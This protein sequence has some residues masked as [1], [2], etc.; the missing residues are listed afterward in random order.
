MKKRIIALILVVVM[1]VLALVGCGEYKY[2]DANLDKFTSVDT[3][4]F[5][6]A[7]KNLVIE[8]EDEFS[9]DPVKREKELHDIVLR[10]LLN[11][12]NADTEE[13]KEGI[14]DYADA[15]YFCYYAKYID[16][17]GVEHIFNVPKT[18]GKTDYVIL[19][20][21]KVFLQFG[22]NENTENP[23]FAAVE[24]AFAD[25]NIK[26]YI[27]SLDTTNDGTLKV[28]A[29]DKV[30]LT[31]TYTDAEGVQK[32]ISN[33]YVT[34][35]TADPAETETAD[36]NDLKSV[37][38]LK[39]FETF[40]WNLVDK[41]VGKELTGTANKFE[42]TL[43]AAPAEQDGEE[44]SEPAS[45]TYT[46]VTVVG[47]ASGEAV[48]V[49][50]EFPDEDK[51]EL[52]D[53]FGNKVDVKGKEVE[54][55]V[56]PTHIKK[57]DY[58]KIDENST[59]ADYIKNA[60]A[61][62]TVFYGSA[63]VQDLVDENGKT[64][65]EKVGA[66]DIFS[67]EE[68]KIKYTNDEGEEETKTFKEIMEQ[69]AELQETYEE[70]KAT[71]D[72][73]V[74]EYEDA[75]ELLESVQK[76]YD[77]AEAALA[78]ARKTL[79]DYKAA[80]QAV[81]DAVAA[82]DAYKA[83]NPEAGEGDAELE[84]LEAAVAAAKTA[85]EELTDLKAEDYTDAKA[86]EKIKLAEDAVAERNEEFNGDPDDEDDTGIVGE[87]ADAKADLEDACE[88]LYGHVNA[89][90]DLYCDNC[91][92]E[93]Q[94][95][96]GAEGH[97]DSDEDC[98]C[99][100]CGAG[101]NHVDADNNCVCD[102]E[103][104]KAKLT[105]KHIDNSDP[106]D[107]KCDNCNAA[108]EHVDSDDGKCDNCQAEFTASDD[109]SIEAA[110]NDALAE[111]DAYLTEKVL[112]EDYKNEADETK[113]FA[114]TIV[115]EFDENVYDVLENTYFTAINN[116]VMKEAYKVIDKYITV[117]RD[118]LPR[119]AV[120]EIYKKIY[121]G[122]KYDFFMSASYADSTYN[123]YETYEG[124]F[125][126]YLMIKT[127]TDT[128]KAAKAALKEEAKDDVEQIVKIYKAAQILNVV[129]TEEEFE[130]D[131]EK[132]Y[133]ETTALIYE[134]YYGMEYMTE[135][136]LH[137]AKQA[138]KLFGHLFATNKTDDKVDVDDATLTFSYKNISYTIKAEAEE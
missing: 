6:E 21:N 64:T 110:F 97:L 94:E 83:E 79:E 20:A 96:C 35:P 38:D 126:A 109:K 58:V 99:D 4:A 56:F 40:L 106:K 115:S 57:V 75:K 101:F 74:S 17:D 117:D 37:A 53:L 26:D 55:F 15:L 116:K 104:C 7:L 111:R 52:T 5:L 76:K 60:T 62:L 22:I 88:L 108:M 30:L 95:I 137:I 69:F 86:D 87:L 70:A 9:T 134:Y 50:V 47:V 135:Q 123:Y 136:D 10:S 16:D 49:K 46:K 11:A 132:E 12:D 54:Y 131:Y 133:N 36:E 128:F 130:V 59:K 112:S 29:G 77:D 92:A 28:A 114:E 119:K 65:G 33:I 67:N 48:N 68:Y 34:I 85:F 2:W 19:P 121:E 120:N 80:K 1:S 45:V 39:F 84:A 14:A 125:E 93:D 90:G 63:S 98:I 78:N 41:T 13:Y 124:D 18:D 8:D 31:F 105:D 44:E 42:Y 66:L 72:K 24:A 82:L 61:I 89:D 51:K 138:D 129:Y 25:K 32:T 71:Y 102:R 113:G 100:T 27:Y 23:L 103:S 122:H 91:G 3:K 118:K 81:T 73:A 107:C 127:G 43:P